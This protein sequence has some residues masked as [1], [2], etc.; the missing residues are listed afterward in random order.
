MIDSDSLETLEVQNADLYPQQI[1]TITT[2]SNHMLFESS[3]LPF[4]HRV[5]KGKGDLS[6]KSGQFYLSL[7]SQPSNRDRAHKMISMPSVLLLHE[8][9]PK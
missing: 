3:H 7:H 8:A 6:A 1:E 5:F 9:I 4:E 2:E